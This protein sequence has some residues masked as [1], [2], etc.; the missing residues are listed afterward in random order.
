MWSL[1]DFEQIK[2]TRICRIGILISCLRIIGNLGVKT[3][4]INYSLQQVFKIDWAHEMGLM[5][6]M[7]HE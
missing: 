4:G 6:Q 1:K 5:S 7:S 2:K 3:H